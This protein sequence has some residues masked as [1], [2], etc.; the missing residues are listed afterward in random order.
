MTLK[1]VLYELIKILTSFT[2]SFVKQNKTKKRV[3]TLQMTLS[4][5]QFIVSYKLS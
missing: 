3:H 5:V 2:P 1:T 4:E